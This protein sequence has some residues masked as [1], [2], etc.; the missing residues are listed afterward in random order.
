VDCNL[1]VRLRDMH[2][3]YCL[4]IDIERFMIQEFGEVEFG[5]SRIQLRSY[6]IMMV[7]RQLVG[8]QT[9]P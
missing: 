8:A 1:H 2:V 4:A 9:S 3:D 5:N 6:T 7:M